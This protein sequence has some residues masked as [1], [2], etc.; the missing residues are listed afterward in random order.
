MGLPCRIGTKAGQEP[1]QILMVHELPLPQVVYQ[2][3]DGI[4]PR[5]LDSSGMDLLPDGR[6]PETLGVTDL[7]YRPKDTNMRGHQIPSC[8]K[9]LNFHVD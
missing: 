7:P 8:S 6:R 5:Y 9:H 1:G 3:I 2:K 4:I